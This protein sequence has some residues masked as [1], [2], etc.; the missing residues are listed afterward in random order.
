MLPVLLV[1]RIASTVQTGDGGE[2]F[3]RFDGKD[4]LVGKAAG[5]GLDSLLE[6]NFYLGNAAGFGCMHGGH[7][8]LDT[9]AQNRPLCVAENDD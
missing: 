2:R 3:V 8:S 7:N 4:R 9:V 1:R 6:R 5:Q